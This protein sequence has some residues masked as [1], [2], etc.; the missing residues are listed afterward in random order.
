MAGSK[1]S[2]GT[3]KPVNRMRT[4]AD[5]KA[6]GKQISDGFKP[7]GYIDVAVKA[8]RAAKTAAPATGMGV[9]SNGPAAKT[10]GSGMGIK[11][12]SN[13]IGEAFKTGGP[14]AASK[15]MRATTK[16]PFGTL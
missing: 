5:F 2:S 8:S 3:G 14:K 12:R 16:K 6:K 11:A 13:T 4:L 9:M 15:A 1:I 10:A 7:G